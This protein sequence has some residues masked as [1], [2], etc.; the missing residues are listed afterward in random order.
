MGRFDELTKLD[1][2]KK[3]H[4]SSRSS[5]PAKK[6]NTEHVSQN[7]NNP[8]DDVQESEFFQRN[9]TSLLANQQTSKLTKKQTSKVASQQTNK[10]ANQQTNLPANSQTSILPLTT[11]EKKKYGT[12]LREESILD[13]QIHAAQSKLKDHELLQEIVDI[14]FKNLKK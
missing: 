10:E 13:I 1:D 8:T 12:Y 5:P 7:R 11:K 4:L 2:E 6:L 9:K 14:Y 3:P